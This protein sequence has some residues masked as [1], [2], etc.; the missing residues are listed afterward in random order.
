M[1]PDVLKLLSMAREQYT[2][3][4]WRVEGD[5]TDAVV[6]DGLWRISMFRKMSLRGGPHVQVEI[7]E[8]T[9]HG[10]TL[11]DAVRAAEEAPA[12][13]ARVEARIAQIEARARRGESTA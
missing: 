13:R 4:S 9:G 7:G 2:G 3:R 8:E 5:G 10:P 1:T 6:T 12:E 11:R